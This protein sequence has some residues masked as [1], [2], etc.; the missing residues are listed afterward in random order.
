MEKKT[1]ESIHTATSILETHGDVECTIFYNGIETTFKL[2]EWLLFC[3]SKTP[4]EE[5][6][7]QKIDYACREILAGRIPSFK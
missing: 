2:K 6:D 3:P 5:M 7:A 1:P 4:L